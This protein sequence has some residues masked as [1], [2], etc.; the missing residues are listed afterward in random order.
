MLLMDT[1]L[2][3]TLGVAAGL[4]TGTARFAMGVVALVFRLTLLARPVLPG[5][6]ATFD[7]GFVAYAGMTK[8]AWAA[9]LHPG[10]QPFEPS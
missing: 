10:S 4:T 1:I 7:S 8:A 5:A 3:M 9:R 6:L 2:T